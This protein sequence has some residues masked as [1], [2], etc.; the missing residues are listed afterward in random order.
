VGSLTSHNPISL[1]G[2]LR[3]SFTFTQVF[4]EVFRKLLPERTTPVA[5]FV[6]ACNYIAK[7]YKSIVWNTARVRHNSSSV[8]TDKTSL[9]LMLYVSC[10]RPSCC[11]YDCYQLNFAKFEINIYLPRTVSKHLDMN[12]IG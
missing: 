11:F 7:D 12:S 3:D 4:L 10:I 8:P 2:L 9:G 1:Q 5:I 6:T